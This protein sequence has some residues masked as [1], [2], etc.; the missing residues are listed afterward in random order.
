MFS[1]RSSLV[2]AMGPTGAG[3]SY[4]LFGKEDEARGMVLRAMEYLLERV[5]AEFEIRA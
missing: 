5:T 4:S 2:T 3:K 1:G